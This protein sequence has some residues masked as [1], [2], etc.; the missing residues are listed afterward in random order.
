MNAFRSSSTTAS[1]AFLRI[2]LLAFGVLLT[3][4]SLLLGRSFGD[5]GWSTPRLI[6]AGVGM[7]LIA[8]S[9]VV[10]LPKA[11]AWV[12]IRG[13]LVFVLNQILLFIWTLL[14]ASLLLEVG[15]RVH[16]QFNPDARIKSVEQFRVSRPLP[17]RD[18]P[19]YSETFLKEWGVFSSGSGWITQTD[20]RLMI[21]IDYQGQY[22]NAANGRRLTTGQPPT[23]KRT[24]YVVGGSTTFAAEV[25]DQH[26]IPS[27]LQVLLNQK[28]GDV[29]R[30]ENLGAV[31]ATVAQQIELL[32]TIRLKEGDVVIF[33]DGVNDITQSLMNGNPR[34]WIVGDNRRVFADLNS[35]QKAKLNLY[36]VF[37]G[38]SEF[39]NLFL[40]PYEIQPAPTHLNDKARVEQLKTE[41]DR[42]YYDGVLES[43]R[44]TQSSGAEFYHFFQPNLFTSSP[45]TDYEKKLAAKKFILY[46]GMQESFNIGNPVLQIT[47]KR[48]ATDGI[49]SFDISDV[50]NN[51][52]TGEEF[53]LDHCHVTHVANHYI[54]LA[55]FDKVAPQLNP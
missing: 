12:E 51:R 23:A 19:Y 48:L 55:I 38:Q 36:N 49:K 8:A 27:Q 46:P 1:L 22:I 26:T 53:Y 4:F 42:V 24:V 50:L 3:P 43:A 16:I 32:K 14:I 6:G 25:P 28:F 2:S 10:S 13:H 41:L 45:M 21:P 11:A 52:P 9:V 33:Y 20:T 17:F 44:L 5:L 40:Y 35:L 18:A 47:T 15:A 34:G 29:Y 37:G 54:A 39:A 7:L 30:V 31:T